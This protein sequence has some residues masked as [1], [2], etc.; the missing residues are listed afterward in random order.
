M[1]NASSWASIFG[2]IEVS[3][4]FVC[5]RMHN[6]QKDDSWHEFQ[7]ACARVNQTNKSETES[8]AL[9]SFLNKVLMVSDT[10]RSSTTNRLIVEAQQLFERIHTYEPQK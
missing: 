7:N 10:Y 8:K 5:T 4:R 1:S 3:I 6:D 2:V 9:R